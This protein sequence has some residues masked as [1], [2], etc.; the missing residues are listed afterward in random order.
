M[1]NS[2]ALELCHSGIDL[3]SVIRKLRFLV[4]GKDP[5]EQTLACEGVFPIFKKLIK[6][7]LALLYIERTPPHCGISPVIEVLVDAIL[8][9]DVVFRS[10]R[11]PNPA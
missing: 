2:G 11:L 6:T 4:E 1:I 7:T 8:E 5:L 9:A 3:M 10:V